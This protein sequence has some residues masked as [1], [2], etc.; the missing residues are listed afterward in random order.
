MDFRNTDIIFAGDPGAMLSRGD[1]VKHFA[2]SGY[3]EPKHF[4]LRGYF[5]SKHFAQTEFQARGNS[6]DMFF[7]IKRENM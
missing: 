7:G 4:A 2:L 1:Y 3:F 6:L 5:G